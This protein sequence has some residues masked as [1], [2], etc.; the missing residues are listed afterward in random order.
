MAFPVSGDYVFPRG[1]A[2]VSIDRKADRGLYFEPN[3][4]LVHRL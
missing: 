1:L 4:W 2:T 3:V